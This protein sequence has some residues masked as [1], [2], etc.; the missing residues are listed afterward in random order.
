[1]K[2]YFSLL[3]I[4]TLLTITARGQDIYGISFND[5]DGNTV[6]LNT[7]QG[8]RILFLIAPVNEADSTRLNEIKDFHRV[9]GDSIVV[10]GIMSI[11]DGYSAANK[12]AIKSLYQSREIT[13]TLSEGMQTLKSSGA[14]QAALMKWLTDRSQNHRSGVDSEGIG[15]KFF[16]SPF[17]RLNGVIP[18][19]T[20][21][22]DPLVWV[23]AYRQ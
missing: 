8:K 20:P 6:S 23:M 10:I 19:A 15:Q 18:A 14:S 11:E 7:L 22:L 17:G 9:H 3:L 12:S 13:I 1:M 5:I 16:I 2:H 4:S 21:L